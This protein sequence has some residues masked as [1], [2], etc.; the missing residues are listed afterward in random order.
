MKYISLALLLVLPTYSMAENFTLFRGQGADTNFLEIIPDIV[1]GDLIMDPT[2]FWGLNYSDTIQNRGNN[3]FTRL[4]RRNN[5]STGW[6]TQITKHTGLQDNYEAHLA[7]LLRTRNFQPGPLNINYAAG[8]GPS[9]AFSIPTYE[10]G[11]DGQ[12]NN[13]E[14]KFESFMTFEIESSLQSLPEWK[15]PIRIHHRSGIYGL[16][17]PPKV[18][19]NFFAI[20]IRR[21][22]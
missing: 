6:E 12:P 17:A 11:P 15:I 10:D 21:S 4:L 22:F 20:G 5:I 1:S 16:V 8:I 19:S 18:G 13:G 14:D 7:I 3:W 2:F 9:Y